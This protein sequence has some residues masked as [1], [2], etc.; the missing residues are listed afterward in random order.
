[1]HIFTAARSNESDKTSRGSKLLLASLR[2]SS[3]KGLCSDQQ[4]TNYRHQMLQILNIKADIYPS[5]CVKTTPPTI[6]EIAHKS[7]WLFFLQKKR[8]RR[9]AT[10]TSGSPT[11][12]FF[13]V[14]LR[15]LDV[16]WASRGR[17]SSLAA[18]KQRK[19]P[20]ARGKE[21]KEGCT[22]TH[23]HLMRA[24]EPRSHSG[25][26]PER[27]LRSHPELPSHGCVALKTILYREL[28]RKTAMLGVVS[29]QD[30]GARP[31]IAQRSFLC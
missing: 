15:Q 27:S 1:M 22:C 23:T 29:L 24:R 10:A 21:R 20:H 9:L 7:L 16:V 6:R 3:L 2:P 5:T 13:V 28:C 19:G 30:E 25:T 31:E 12:N 4:L 17:S 8:C 14:P 11:L 26:V 18:Q